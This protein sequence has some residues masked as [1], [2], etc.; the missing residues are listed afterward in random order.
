MMSI[1][2]PM[3]IVHIAQSYNQFVSSCHY[4]GSC[5]VKRVALQTFV[6]NEPGFVV[7][8]VIYGTGA[9]SMHSGVKRSVAK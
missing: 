3:D 4:Y 9:W 6:V 8:S 7:R 2:M 1:N 5:H